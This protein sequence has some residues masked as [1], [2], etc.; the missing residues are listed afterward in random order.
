MRPPLAACAQWCL[1]HEPAR[2]SPPSPARRPLLKVVG[3]VS[4]RPAQSPLAPRLVGNVADWPP[5]R[6]AAE[7]PTALAAQA[8]PPLPAEVAEAP[9][10]NS[11]ARC[12]RERAPARAS[13]P[14][15]A[16]APSCA[17]GGH[18]QPPV[19]LPPPCAPCAA[20]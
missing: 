14:S 4:T 17:P 16:C 20:P 19:R 18:A 6:L 10:P 7:R 1:S 2:S 11:S 5:A 15:S 3:A 8:A 12:S 9:H 13:P